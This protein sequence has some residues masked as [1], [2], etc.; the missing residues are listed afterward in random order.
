MMLLQLGLQHMVGTARP[1]RALPVTCSCC[2]RAMAVAS[3]KSSEGQASVAVLQ[4][5]SSS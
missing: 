2:T 4:A 3:V 5:D 1:A